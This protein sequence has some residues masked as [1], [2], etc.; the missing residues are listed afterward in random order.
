[1]VSRF[2]SGSLL[3]FWFILSI[4]YP[5]TPLPVQAFLII[6]YSL[7]SPVPLPLYKQSLSHIAVARLSDLLRQL[8]NCQQHVTRGLHFRSCYLRLWIKDCNVI[9]TWVSRYPCF[10]ILCHL[11]LYTPLLYYRPGGRLRPRLPPNSISSHL[12]SALDC[13]YFLPCLISTTSLYTHLRSNY[14]PPLYYN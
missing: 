3:S 10:L 9:T 6:I 1:M 14:L 2:T 7:I 4:F 11:V 12:P 13:V 5:S 8:F